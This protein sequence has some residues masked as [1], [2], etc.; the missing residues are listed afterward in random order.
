MSAALKSI[1]CDLWLHGMSIVV[2]VERDM[3]GVVIRQLGELTN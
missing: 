3:D 1:T 2:L